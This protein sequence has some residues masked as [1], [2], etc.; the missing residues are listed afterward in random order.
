MNY[1]QSKI[2][3]GSL[4][5]PRFIGGPIDGYI[6]A[7]FRCLIHEFSPDA[8]LYREIYHVAEV[9][10]KDQGFHIMAG[11]HPI[12]VQLTAHNTDFIE[13][14]CEI[15]IASGA[16]AIDINIGCPAPHIV[17][18]GSGSSLMADIPRLISIV[19]LFRHYV[20]LPLTVKMRAGFSICNACEVAK[21]MED[22]GVDALVV[23]PR[24]QKQRFKGELDYA[25]VAEIKKE[26]S[27]PVILSGGISSL[28]T[29]HDAYE[30]T[31]VDGFLIGRALIGKPWLLKKLAEEVSGKLYEATESVK[32]NAMKKYIFYAMEYY[33]DAVL[34][35]IKRQCC[36]MLKGSV[37]SG[38][39]RQAISAA[40][41]IQEVEQILATWYKE[42]GWV[43]V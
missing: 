37:Q 39:A 7:P 16:D 36:W 5:G 11:E 17:K 20:P 35:F 22:V 32:Y 26:V 40:K 21:I 10:K 8:L 31:G 9:A 4:S 38:M 12:N 25:L 29:A 1:W 42:S 33:D 30:R 18:S 19:K 6:D 28:Q 14:A 13:K 23:H 34:P 27:I 3:I 43:D 2:A 41:N 15:V 24:L